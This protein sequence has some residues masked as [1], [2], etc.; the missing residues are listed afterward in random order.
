MADFTWSRDVQVMDAVRDLELELPGRGTRDHVVERTGYARD[1]V[2]D[3]LRN[4]IDGGY[5]TG[6]DWGAKDDPHN[7]Y[8][9]RLT[10]PGRRVVGQWPSTDPADALVKLLEERLAETD[11]EA[12]ATKLRRVLETVTEVGAGVLRDTLTA[13]IRATAGI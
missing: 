9:L 4:L 2:T 5:V 11:D 8:D 10:A 13:L 1:E 3:S 12:E 6:R 7:W